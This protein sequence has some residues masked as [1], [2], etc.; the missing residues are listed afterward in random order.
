MATVSPTVQRP[1]A[2]TSP[3]REHAPSGVA[4]RAGRI[5]SGAVVVLLAV[6]SLAGLLIG[7]LYQDPDAVVSMLRGYDLATLVA[8]VPVLAATLTPSLRGS[9]RTRLVAAGVLAFVVYDYAYY[10]FGAAFN[11]LFLLHVATFSTALFALTLTLGSMDASRLATRFRTRAPV[12]T[13]ATILGLM[14][15]SLA[16][17]WIAGSLGF[18]LNG[19]VPD[20]GNGLVYPIEITHLGYAMDLALLVPAYALA[21]VLLWRRRPWGHVV[22]LV[23]LVA[24]VFTQLTYVAALVFQSRAGIPGAVAFDPFDPF[25]PVILA[26]YLGGAGLLL[27]DLR[28]GRHGAPDVLPLT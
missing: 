12:R 25:E 28:R 10:V 1:A 23:A 13:V 15:A 19:T 4:V 3:S 26:A 24:G 22:G 8:A 18:A 27:A 9:V 16:G 5:L 7:A 6:S 21:A 2:A 14:A 17:M 11:D 20:D